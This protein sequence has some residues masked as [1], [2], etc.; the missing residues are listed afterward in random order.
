MGLMDAPPYEA[1]L[2]PLAVAWR[3]WSFRPIWQQILVLAVLSAS[4]LIGCMVW[5]YHEAYRCGIDYPHDGQCG[6]ESFAGMAFGVVGALITF[7]IGGFVIL[8]R[9]V[10]SSKADADG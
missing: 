2:S 8:F 9:A 7:L 3:W 4:V 6:L 5:G 1:R 10:R